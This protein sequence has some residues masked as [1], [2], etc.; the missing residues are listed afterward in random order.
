MK[1]KIYVAMMICLLFSLFLISVNAQTG[2]FAEAQGQA[3]LRADTRTDAPIVGQIAAGTRYPVIGRSELYPWL[4]LGDPNNLQPLGWAFQDLLIVTGNVNSVP[5]SSLIIDGRQ[6]ASTLAMPPS[7]TAASGV[8]PN[9][10]ASLTPTQSAPATATTAF[11]VA[12]IV[13]G[14][15]NVRYG[16]GVDFPRIGVANVGDRFQVT[17]YHTQVPWV[18]VVYPASPNQLAWLNRDV[19]QIE[20]DIFSLP[21]VTSALINLPPLQP[22]TSLVVSGNALNPQVPSS[23]AFTQLGNDIFNMMLAR[24]FDPATSK[25]G[26]FFLMD[27]QT[28]E[29][30]SV[31]NDVAFSGTSVMKVAIMARLYGSLS[32][33]PDA[34]TAVD[35]ANTMI[36]SENAATNRLL[37]IVGSGDEYNGADEVT[38][39]MNTLGLS[40]S[41]I[42]AP[43]ALNLNT[44]VTPPPNRAVIA[45][46]T[47]VDQTKSN[48]DYTNQV[49]VDDMGYLLADIYQCAYQD[50]GPLLTNFSGAYEPRECR[51]MLH[52]MSNNTV[53]ALLKAGVPADTRVAHK[54]GWINDTHSN[55]AVFFTP[56]GDYVMVMAVHQPSWLDFSESLPM[57]AE[58]SRMVYNY[59]NPTAP[60]STVREGFIPETN[61]CNY[62]NSQ[63]SLDL[64]Q[65]IWDN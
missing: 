21:A 11:N 1:L 40:D 26:A 59:F 55:A 12:A 27:L 15:I 39:F 22:T 50:S 65:P 35:V 38:N 30:I 33:P 34:R 57:I 53:D 3:N 2:V 17:R 42:I 19:I 43:Y 4:L 31:G 49:T 14:E 28:G 5:L 61:S 54:H 9:A 58:A 45:P 24:G 23:P 52:V 60:M 18:E 48:P 46:T 10:S 16:P 47:T 37:S 51:Q 36:C 56:G 25:F 41:F 62:T 44:P 63:L 29:A 32:T 8:V 64:R 13:Q 6:I 7:P 20:G